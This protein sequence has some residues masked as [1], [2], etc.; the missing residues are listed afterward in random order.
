MPNGTPRARKILPTASRASSSEHD[1][2]QSGGDTADDESCDDK[3]GTRT[4]G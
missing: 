4:S 3:A 2:A 1:C